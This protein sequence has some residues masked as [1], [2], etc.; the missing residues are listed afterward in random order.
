MF[1]NDTPH[2]EIT[3]GRFGATRSNWTYHTAISIAQAC[4][5]LNLTCRFEAGGKQDALI[6]TI[7]EVPEII[8][9]AEWEWEF[10]D[11]FGKGKE[12]DKLKNTCNRQP[13][14]N[15]FLLIYCPSE[16]YLDHLDRIAQDWISSST[17]TQ[18]PYLYLHTIIFENN[19]NMRGFQL[20]KTVVI[21]K[22]Q[23]EVWR[24]TVFQ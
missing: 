3:P 7:D 8:L 12:L 15:A 10:D 19:G 21:H 16:K 13:S 6:E 4:K 2:Y 20:L 14:A 23:I 22:S 24:D 17:E 9:A 5:I 1:C 11:I 18:S